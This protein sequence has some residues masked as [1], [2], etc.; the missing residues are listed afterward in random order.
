MKTLPL[1][2]IEISKKNLVH[3]IKQFRG[4]IKKRT[5]IAGVIK[6]N[7]YGHG[8]K[9]VA[10][11]LAPYVDYFQINSTEELEGLRNVTKKP[12]LLLG[13][14]GKNDLKRSI[15]LGCILTVF[16]FE[17]MLLVNQAARSLG[18]KQKVH[19]AVDAHLGREG[20]TLPDL[21]FIMPE[22]G[23]MKN[24]NIDG[25][26]A[27]F[28]NIEDIHPDGLFGTGEDFSHA[29]SQIDIYQKVLNIFRTY[30]YNKIHTHISATSGVLVYEQ[31]LGLNSIV[32]VG[33]GLYG[34]WPS[35]D[36]KN[37]YKNKMVLKPVMR[38]VTHV[39]QVKTLPKG[40]S[41]GYGLTYVT[42]KET[43]I[44]VI[45]QGYSNGLPRLLSNKGSVLIESKRAP[46]LGRVAMNMFVVDVTHIKNVVSE[47][48]VVILGK[49][50]SSEITA[51]DL[52]EQTDTIN[53]EVTTR[54]SALLPRVVK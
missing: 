10:K 52:A 6:A 28:A 33:V 25:V 15:K 40:H 48:E 3:N 1:S 18:V 16:D 43:K 7:A 2:Y 47:S 4:L 11:I 53:Y 26:Y 14:V 5:K 34:M 51:E 42:D 38:W 41:I 17:H 36:L 24:I 35:E 50:G 27:H 20:F 54:V 46:I 19:V 31:G 49:Q 21:E 44:A 37:K 39:A 22:I 29:R 45:P 13:Y 30:G 32:R 23:K 9:E 12:I 8:D